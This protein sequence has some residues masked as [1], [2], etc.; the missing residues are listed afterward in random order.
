MN[1]HTQEYPSYPLS[2]HPIFTTSN[3]FIST[4]MPGPFGGPLPQGEYSIRYNN[5]LALHVPNILTHT[6]VT[7][8]APD[9]RNELQV[10]ALEYGTKGYR[11]KNKASGNYLSYT[12]WAVPSRLIGQYNHI[13]ASDDTPVEWKLVQ[14]S[15]SNAQRTFQLRMIAGNDLQPTDDIALGWNGYVYPVA[16]AQGTSFA[17]RPVGN[18]ATAPPPSSLTITN[19]TKCLIR[20]VYF[21]NVTLDFPPSTEGFVVGRTINNTNQDSQVW[22]FQKGGKGFKIRN[23]QAEDNLGYAVVPN[24]ALAS[25]SMVCRDDTST[26]YMII[27][28]T[29]GFEIR[30]VTDPTLV[31][32]IWNSIAGSNSWIFL[33]KGPPNGSAY[34][35][36][37]WVFTAPK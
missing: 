32:T 29:E 18:L 17:F 15:V 35:N 11:I 37:Q 10:W 33:D 3:N 21:P 20:S 22:N 13:T 7:M 5:D 24:T 2:S 28:S 23:V 34:T 26:E 4:F 8:I 16:G 9:E 14:T 31:V 30:P 36:Q 25:P 19:N 1:R 27:P 6:V 12:P